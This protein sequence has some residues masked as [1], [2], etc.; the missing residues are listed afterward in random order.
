M[1][2]AD[3]CI[4]LHLISMHTRT[5]TL[6][7][8]T[9]TSLALSSIQPIRIR[10]LFFFVQSSNFSWVRNV[11][12]LF[13]CSLSTTTPFVV[14]VNF[15]VFVCVCFSEYAQFVYFEMQK[16]FRTDFRLFVVDHN[17]YTHLEYGIDTF[18]RTQKC[19]N[20]NHSIWKWMKKFFFFCYFSVNREREKSFRF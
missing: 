5:H 12:T 6:V 10:Y 14:V 15:V 7:Y 9:K 1:E 13:S 8:N 18:G 11:S 16:I 3:D 4:V 19:K 2:N 17:V 20:Q